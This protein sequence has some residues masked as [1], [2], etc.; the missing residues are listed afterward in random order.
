[1]RTARMDT[2][3]TPMT[4]R[5]TRR[6]VLR[7]GGA[8]VASAAFAAPPNAHAQGAAAFGEALRK[9]T[10]GGQPQLGK[11]VIAAPEVA[12]NGATVPIAL[13]VDHPMAP[14]NYVRRITVLADGNPNPEVAVFYLT[15][16]SGKA[17]VSTRV[18]LA[19]SQNLVAIAELSDN[20]LWMAKKEV[21]VTI[22]G[23]GG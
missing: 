21:R 14:T 9:A 12:E 10:G 23:C 11:V 8:L 2:H 15:P 18:R 3:A 6:Q 16:R 5:P 17:E 13:S 7:A 20:S 4:G 22:G 1:M 19:K